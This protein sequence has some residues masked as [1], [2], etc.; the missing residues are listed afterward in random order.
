VTAAV[1]V[2]DEVDS[3]V[4]RH[5][6][7]LVGKRADSYGSKALR[8]YTSTVKRDAAEGDDAS[9]ILA[10][11]EESTCSR[12]WFAC[13]HC[14]HWQPLDWESVTYQGENEPQ[15]IASARYV[16]SN[17]AVAWT[18]DDRQRSIRNWRCVHKGQMVDQQSG[19][20][21]GS[22]TATVAFG[23]LWTALDSS[24]RSLGQLAGDHWRAKR[25]LD[26]GDHGPMRSFVRDQLCR[27]YQEAENE[28]PK[29]NELQ[30]AARS[31]HGIQRG[32]IPEDAV[33]TAVGSDV[34]KRDAWWAAVSIADDGRWWIV[35]Y[36]RTQTKRETMDRV[37]EPSPAER[38]EMLDRLHERVLQIGRANASCIDVAYTPEVVVPWARSK[39]WHCVRGD[40]RPTGH[41]STPLGQWGE[42]R[43]QKAG[44]NITFI[45]GDEVKKLLHSS[46][47]IDPGKPGAG[48]VP[49]GEAA[50][51]W[52][53]RHLCSEVYTTKDGWVKIRP[54]NHLLD[55]VVYAL[56]YCLSRRKQRAPLANPPKYGVSTPLPPPDHKPKPTGPAPSRYGVAGTN[57]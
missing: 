33:Y 17:C 20:V 50:Q 22:F 46:L 34:G 26:L 56:A 10:L 36:G 11:Y 38:K 19:S 57:R 41:D 35:D 23:L 13:P 8:I 54:Q 3:Y 15:A 28:V 40:Q 39:G 25:A 31:Q 1:V 51:D 16:C 53:I 6:V 45:K 48:M 5:R 47:A 32:Q 12:L 44:H 43:K 21:V 49:H 30:L 52:L 37:E 42:T 2:C 24:L 4:S 18:E 9:I 55:C 29:S 27:R 7:E 14:G